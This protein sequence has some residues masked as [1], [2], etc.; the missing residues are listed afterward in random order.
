MFAYLLVNQNFCCFSLF[1]CMWRHVESQENQH[2]LIK[3]KN[4]FLSVCC[5]RKQLIH[6]NNQQ[7]WLHIAFGR[8]RQVGVA[9]CCGLIPQAN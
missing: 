6:N 2:Q 4:I 1:M 3:H 9:F 7:A 8:L 5:W